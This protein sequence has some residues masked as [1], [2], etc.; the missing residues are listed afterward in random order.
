MLGY[1]LWKDFYRDAKKKI[2]SNIQKI[3]E[4]AVDISVFV[5]TDHGEN[6]VN[7]RSQT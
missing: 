7:R 1:E 3:R 5:D 4:L 2:P 6:K